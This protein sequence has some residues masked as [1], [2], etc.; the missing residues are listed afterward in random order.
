MPVTANSKISAS[1]YN[2]I[3]NNIVSVMGV[4]SAS[5]GYG[6]AIN[7]SSKS[8]NEIID[9][10]D[11]DN[12]RF[13]IVNARIHQTGAAFTVATNASNALNRSQLQF[14]TASVGFLV[15]GMAVF[16]IS[17]HPIVGFKFITAI[18]TSG[19]NTIITLDAPTE[20]AVPSGTSIYFGTA[21]LS[22]FEEGV[23]V[24]ATNINNYDSLATTAAGLV[25]RFS[26]AVGQFA[27]SSASS[28]SRTWSSST[29]P[30]FWS[31]EINTELT[32][33]F[34]NSN[35]ARYYFN[36]GGEVRIS[37]SRTGGRSDQQNNAWSSLLTSAGVRNFGGQIPTTG[38]SPMNGQN[39]Y[40]L[41]STYQSWYSIASSSP[42]SANVYQLEAKCNVADNSSGTANIVYIR[43]RFIGGYVDPGDY[44][45][46]SPR[47]NDEIDGTFAVTA[48]QK[49]ASGKLLPSG[50]FSV[51]LPSFG[52][53]SITG[54]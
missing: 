38:F 50:N 46:D 17:P 42:Y 20:S 1:D 37:S 15:Q 48:T 43:V 36:S 47:T 30:Q 6:Q 12:L 25:D 51:V 31:S 29:S 3:R 32:I 8:A 7:S 11:W 44:F 14:T 18:G 28:V 9:Q 27:T 54:S 49:Y 4:G 52:F 23:K 34:S 13:D 53:S 24:S 16:G 21:S 10:T 22:D 39:F 5:F 45:L 2:T 26:V 40:R 35:D 33:T 41:T 19:A